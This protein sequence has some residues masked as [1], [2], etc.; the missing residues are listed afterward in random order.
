VSRRDG[1]VRQPRGLQNGSGRGGRDRSVSG[2]AHSRLS[3]R[4]M[5]KGSVLGKVA[6]VRVRKLMS[7]RLGQRLENGR[8]A[9]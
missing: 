6:K 1:S 7:S 8:R 3:W 9:R 2:Q 5:E 4:V